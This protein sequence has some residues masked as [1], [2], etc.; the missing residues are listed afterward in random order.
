[1]KSTMQSMLE[2]TFPGL[3]QSDYDLTS[4]ADDSYNC[5]AWAANDTTKWWWP[6]EYYW[7]KPVQFSESVA[8]F[9][10]AFCECLGYEEC[11]SGDLEIGYQKVAIYAISGNVKHMARQLPDGKWTSK[12]GQWVD[13][14][15][16]VHGVEGTG[17]GKVVQFL[18]KKI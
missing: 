18:R 17:Y 12:L 5:I 15:H 14:S 6:G 1:L 9:V 13:I 11:E 8:L 2:R 3:M 10:E 4:K 16:A 7:P